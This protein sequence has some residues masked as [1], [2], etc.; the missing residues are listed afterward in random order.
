MWLCKGFAA[1]SVSRRD[2]SHR[3]RS[4]RRVH[5]CKTHV[6]ASKLF[7]QGH[8]VNLLSHLLT[9][10]FK[11]THL[12]YCCFHLKLH[13]GW[14][15]LPRACGWRRT[16]VFPL[17]LALSV[18]ARFSW[19]GVKI[20]LA[21]ACHFHKSWVCRDVTVNG[22]GRG[23]RRWEPAGDQ[24][25]SQPPGKMLLCKLKL[26]QVLLVCFIYY[27]QL[28][29]AHVFTCKIYFDIDFECKARILFK[30]NTMI[31]IYNISYCNFSPCV[32]KQHVECQIVSHSVVL[33]FLWHRWS[34]IYLKIFIQNGF[35]LT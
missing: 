3:V 17:F 26:Q 23:W 8:K 35:K 31:C 28:S 21:N 24:S 19:D 10:T 2:P 27:H 4:C 29:C 22:G 25:V 13:L 18:F 33:Y 11:P 6:N 12:S 5:Q 1:A 7:S 9:I 15:C 14:K 30:S 32:F 34:C 16:W 20:A